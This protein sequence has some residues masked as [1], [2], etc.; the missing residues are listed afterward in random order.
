MSVSERVIAAGKGVVGAEMVMHDN[1][2][3]KLCG[4]VPARL[5]DPVEGV[6]LVRHCMQPLHGACDARAG[7]VEMPDLGLPGAR[8]VAR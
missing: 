2:A 1:A 7:F 5:A 8:P 6:A 3:L 4:N